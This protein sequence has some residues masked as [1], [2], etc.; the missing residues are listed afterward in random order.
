MLGIRSVG[1]LANAIRE[2]P[3]SLYETADRVDELVQLYEL[4]NPAA[5]HKKVRI[6]RCP[7]GP[8]RR[9]QTSLLRLLFRPRLWPS[10]HSYGG[11]PGR[12]AVKNAAAHLG[13]QFI[14]TC[15]IKDFFPSI[16]HVRV[17]ELFA[18]RLDCSDEVAA[19]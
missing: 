14:Y 11:V 19:L 5:P 18:S 6:V 13:S 7:T 9:V 3:R 4:S 16:K 12:S 17:R 8:L 15:D 10:R 2:T 1:E